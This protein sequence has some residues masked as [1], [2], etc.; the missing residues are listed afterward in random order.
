MS[1]CEHQIARIEWPD[2]VQISAYKIDLFGFDEI[3]L[4]FDTARDD[5]MV[6]CVSEEEEGWDGLIEAIERVFPGIQKWTDWFPQVAVPAF[7]ENR[8]ALWERS[9]TT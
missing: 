1:D 7:A 9:N 4:D 5:G 6:V 3:R 2:V 8:T